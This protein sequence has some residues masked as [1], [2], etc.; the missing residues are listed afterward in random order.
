[1]KS[2]KQDRRSRRT[3]QLIG[4]ALVELMLEKQYSAITVQDI[5]DRANV[6]RSTFYAHFADKEALLINQIAQV[7][8]QLHINTESDGHSAGLLPSLEFFRHIKAQQ[9]L[10]HAFVWGRSGGLLMHDFQVKVSQIVAEKLDHH[11]KP[12]TALPVPK[13]VIASFV[14]G[15]LVMLILWWIE[16]G[17]RQTP[18]E[19][20]DMF[21]QLVYPSISTLLS[22]SAA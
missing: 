18:E 12:D 1:M 7:I 6:G 15:T 22:Q 13:E 2:L 19:M 8:E 11:L 3:Q 20:D 14:V 16:D 9:R 4:N 10:I 21:R 17:M 5:L